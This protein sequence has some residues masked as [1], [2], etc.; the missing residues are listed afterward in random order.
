MKE[1]HPLSIPAS[2]PV[3]PNTTIRNTSHPSFH[4]CALERHVHQFTSRISKVLWLT[5]DI[6]ILR[7][8]IRIRI[9]SAAWIVLLKGSYMVQSSRIYESHPVHSLLHIQKDKC[10]ARRLKAFRKSAKSVISNWPLSKNKGTNSRY[11]FAWYL[12]PASAKHSRAVASKA[13][14]FAGESYW[15]EELPIANFEVPPGIPELEHAD[16]FP[17]AKW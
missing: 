1:Q 8:V 12:L 9:A 3:A 2:K 14:Q 13:L 11:S 5:A 10:P 6:P 15:G 4:P 17:E 7:P 16:F